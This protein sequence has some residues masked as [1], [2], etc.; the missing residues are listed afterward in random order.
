MLQSGEYPHRDGGRVEK[1]TD[2]DLAP[3]NQL[4]SAKQQQKQHYL[5]G[6]HL[7]QRCTVLARLLQSGEYPHR[8]G[9]R[10][11][12][13]ADYDLAPP[14]QLVSAKQQQKQ[15]YLDGVHLVQ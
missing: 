1:I 15:H 12:K 5:D 8:D 10:V 11:E 2:Y 14:N 9:G 6:V 13:I 4:V 3:P 7:F